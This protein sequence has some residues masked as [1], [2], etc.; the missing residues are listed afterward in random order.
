MKKLK[1]ILATTTISAMMSVTAFAG[2]WINANNNW[3]Y[4][5]NGANLTGWQVVNDNWYY[6]NN[7]GAM[8]SDWQFIDNSWFFFNNQHD[9]TFGAMKTGWVAPHGNW[10][11]M[12]T[13]HDGTFGK[14]LTNTVT[15]DGYTLD[16]NGNCVGSASQNTQYSIRQE[17]KFNKLK[18]KVENQIDRLIDKGITSTSLDKVNQLKGTFYSYTD[19]M[20]YENAKQ[21]AENILLFKENKKNTQVKDN[22]RYDN[23]SHT[24]DTNADIFLEE[25]LDNNYDTNNTE[26]DLDDYANEILSLINKERNKRGIH[27]VTLSS[28]LSG[29]AEERAVEI[30]EK[31]SHTRPNGERCFTILDNKDSYHYLGENIAGG[32]TSSKEVMDGWMH[33]E[34]HKKNILNTKFDEVGIGLYKNS[35][36]TYTYYWVQMFG[37]KY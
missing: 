34:G 20:D 13:N 3:Y 4:Q 7:E 18:D 12:N 21:I 30:N 2:T 36:S 10:Y 37:T 25:D 8:L 29:A 26:C 35:S 1:H 15:P 11:Y 9:G 19:A 28:E 5:D 22:T 23:Y 24:K 6:F 33:S 16:N 27:S 14:M 17:E 31:F 32:Q